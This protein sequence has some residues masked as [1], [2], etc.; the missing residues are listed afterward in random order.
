MLTPDQ[1][2]TV[3]ELAIAFAASKL[4]VGVYRPLND[5]ER[6]DMIL[7]IRGRLLRVQCKSAARYA[8][9]VVIRCFSSR[10]ARSGLVRRLYTCAEVDAIAAY[11]L[12][13]DRCFLLP[14][15]VLEGH[16]EVRLR[17]RPARNNQRLGIRW[18]DE[19]DFA[20]TLRAL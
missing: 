4:G 6:Y 16:P 15:S 8:D 7:E 14:M 3:A 1:K 5:G 10:R 12:E 13:L 11:C 20:A 17:L 18:G 9:G 2:G 19:F